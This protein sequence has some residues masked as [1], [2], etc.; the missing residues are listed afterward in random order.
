MTEQLELPLET[1]GKRDPA[2]DAPEQDEPEQETPPGRTV[3]YYKTHGAERVAVLRLV[4]MARTRTHK[5]FYGNESHPPF[6]CFVKRNVPQVYDINNFSGFD[7]FSDELA[8][9][10]WD[11][12]VLKVWD[13][14]EML[15]VNAVDSVLKIY[16][17]PVRED[18]YSE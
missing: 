11:M 16:N 18:L 10:V 8:Q 7:F 15:G 6:S 17:V 2:Y 4:S 14:L 12:T 13:G 5:A 9:K 1:I 3:K